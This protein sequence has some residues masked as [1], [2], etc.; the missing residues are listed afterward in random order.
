M[1]KLVTFY[2]DQNLILVKAT[3]ES[4]EFVTIEL[5]HPSRALQLIITVTRAT[6]S[7]QNYRIRFESSQSK[8]AQLIWTWQ[9]SM[10]HS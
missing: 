9:P 3:I 4:D 1:E 10:S 2:I 8:Y 7:L 5:L 6:F